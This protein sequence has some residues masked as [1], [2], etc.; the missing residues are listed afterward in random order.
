MTAAAK[1]MQ[2]ETPQSR[3][4]DLGSSEYTSNGVLILDIEHL[5][6]RIRHYRGQKKSKTKIVKVVK[7]RLLT[8]EAPR[9][10][11]KLFD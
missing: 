3:Q 5:T 8:A 1:A 4:F 7:R 6:F 2:V 10:R 9:H 11:E